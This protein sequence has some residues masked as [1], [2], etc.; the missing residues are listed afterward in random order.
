[1]DQIR[2]ESIG[3]IAKGKRIYAQLKSG[4]I[5]EDD[6]GVDV[7]DC[8]NNKDWTMTISLMDAYKLSEYLDKVDALER[9][10]ETVNFNLKLSDLYEEMRLVIT[11]KV[12]Q[13][14]TI[15]FF[16]PEKT[17]FVDKDRG[18]KLNNSRFL[19]EVGAE[20]IID[21]MGYS[22]SYSRLSYE[23]LTEIADWIQNF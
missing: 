17:I 12:R 10:I 3:A 19:T 14:G 21:N 15:S 16:S 6:L 23:Q 13:R 18:F 8:L 11:N 4:G 2:L 1:M 5:D 20:T 7:E 22:Y 9:P